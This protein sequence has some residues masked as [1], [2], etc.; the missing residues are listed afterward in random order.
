MLATWATRVVRVAEL[1]A[2]LTVALSTPQRN[3]EGVTVIAWLEAAWIN[4][5]GVLQFFIEQTDDRVS[6]HQYITGWNLP[7]PL[8]QQLQTHSVT[9]T[10]RVA[11]LMREPVGRGGFDANM[12]RHIVD[13]A[14]AFLAELGR[15]PECLDW[16]SLISGS[17][18]RASTIVGDPARYF[19]V[20]DLVIWRSGAISHV[21]HLGSGGS[22]RR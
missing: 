16:A 22:R 4:A 21:T 7:A 10:H 5:R 19:S 11:H 18:K 13:A 14:E 3:V 15:R 12:A 9:I 8:A 2:R 20:D 6:L 17:I 1:H